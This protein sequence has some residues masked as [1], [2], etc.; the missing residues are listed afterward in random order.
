MAGGLFAGVML[1]AGAWQPGIADTLRKI[2]MQCR[3]KFYY[4]V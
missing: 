1:V 4:R 2:K 3:P